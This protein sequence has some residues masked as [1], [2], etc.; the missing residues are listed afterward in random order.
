VGALV[1]GLTLWV[2]AVQQSAELGLL[3]AIGLPASRLY[4]LVVWQALIVSALGAAVGVAAGYL[5]ADAL[6]SALPRFV[7]R[8]PWWI[9]A[10]VVCGAVAVGLVAAL[11]PLRAVRRVEPG[12]VF[13]A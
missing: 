11:V 1:V 12:L 6:G 10:G 8:L 2:S 9:A 7:T 4:G 3:K 13:R 5:T